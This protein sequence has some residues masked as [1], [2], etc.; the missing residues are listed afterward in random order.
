MNILITGGASGLGRSITERF[1]Q[2]QTNKVYFTFKNSLTNAIEITKNFSNSEGIKCDFTNASDLA[3]LCKKISEIDLDVLIN[4]AYNLTPFAN[5]Q[6]NQSDTF[7]QSFKK[8]ILP[9]IDITQ[10]A[11]NVFR[12]KKSGSIITILTS[13]LLN[14]PPSGSAV[15]VADKAYIEQLTKVWASENIRYNIRSNSVSPSFMQTP[16]TADTDERIIE[17]MQNEHPLKRLLNPA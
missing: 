3:A 10:A 8:N 12:A 5:F 15:Y 14:V 13:Y 6:K 1:A 16:M 7:L 2:E 4:N 9:V 17:Q 11:I